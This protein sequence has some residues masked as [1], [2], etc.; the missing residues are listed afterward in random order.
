MADEGIFVHQFELGPWDNFI[1]LIGDRVTRTCAVVDPAW[2]VD[3]ILAEADRLGVE[4]RHALCTHS[5]FDHVNQVDALL[6]KKDIP[7]HMLGEEIDF[8][9]F[10]SEN[11]ERHRAGD[12]LPIGDHLEV[13]FVHTPGHTPGSTT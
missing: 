7:V 6:A 3:V 12:V 11:L 2:D 9:D 1:Y 13:T 4:I 8:A 10:R 5:H